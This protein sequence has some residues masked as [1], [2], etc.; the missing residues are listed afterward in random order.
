MNLENETLNEAL[1]EKQLIADYQKLYRLAYSYVHNENDALDIVQESAYKAV[2][3]SHTLKNPQYAGTWIYRIVI[4]ES[5]SFLRKQ[6]QQETPLYE[7]DGETEDSYQDVD[8]HQALEQLEPIDKTV[9][10]L[11]YFEGM[12]LNQI[13]QTLDENLSTVKSRLYRSLKKLRVS[14]EEEGVQYI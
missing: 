10:I 2:K 1:I 6:K 8:L 5:I 9:I 12:Q 14:M 3:N 4:N 7:A 13:A 11:R